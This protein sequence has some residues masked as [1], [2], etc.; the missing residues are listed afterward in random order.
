VSVLGKLARSSYQA[1]RLNRAAH[2]PGRYAR[3]RVISKGLGA[4]G[5]WRLMGRIWR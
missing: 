1:H 3:N 2:N 4:V 5:F